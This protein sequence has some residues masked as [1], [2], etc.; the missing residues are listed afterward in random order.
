MKIKTLVGSGDKITVFTL[1]ILLIG[2]VLTIMFPQVF[3]VG[4][5]PRAL[6]TVSGI[7]LFLGIIIWIWSAVLILL[8]IPKKQLIPGGP[9]AIVKHPLYI[10]IAFL[11]LPWVGFL[12]NTWLGVLIGITLYIATKIFTPEEEIM[13]SKA[14][15]PAWEEYSKKVKLP[16]L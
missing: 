12:C 2:L 7:I 9:Y 11:V 3:R 6:M 14:F 4:G 13:L 5:P 8:N 15:G 1:P 16:W 10:N